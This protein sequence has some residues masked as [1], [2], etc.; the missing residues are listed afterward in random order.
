MK[1]L[2]VLL[3]VT[4]IE[5]F[6]TICMER[7]VYFLTH[8]VAG[9]SDAM[10]LSLALALGVAYVAGALLSHRFVRIG[11][12]K[13]VVLALV[14]LQLL[15]HLAMAAVWRMP[16]A[17]FASMAVVGLLNGAKWPVIESYVSAGWNARDTARAVGRFCLAWSG[18]VPLAL[19]ASGPLIQFWA[20]SLFL[21][22]AAVNLAAL[23]LLWLRLPARP[24]HLPEEHPDHLPSDVVRRYRGLLTASQAQLLAGYS[25]LFILGPLLP[26][27]FAGLNVDT[28]V[29]TGLSG[30]LDGFRF[31]AF[32]LLGLWTAWHGRR[33]MILLGAMAMPAGFFLALFG[34]SVPAVLAGEALF[35]LATGCVYYAALYYA[36]MVHRASVGA[37]GSHEG[38]IGSGFALGPALGLAGVAMAGL[39]HGN[40]TA[41]TI[42]ATTPLLVACLAVTAWK[43]VRTGRG[44]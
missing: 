18:A 37:G 2:S 31:A 23:L 7:G 41:G 26:G 11:G 5:S 39:F 25:A 13:R 43:L 21:L 12:E 9:Y 15:A 28:S 17:L 1:R 16:V 4:F 3:L 20:P 8:D 44:R 38:I 29:A 33:D 34:G 35:G 30:L 10:N 6:A 32:L 27:V 19:L 22:P 36:M 42:L 40:T 24:P 14:F